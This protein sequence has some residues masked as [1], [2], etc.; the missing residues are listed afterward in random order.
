MSVW[1]LLSV[2]TICCNYQS[3]AV[4]Q[5]INAWLADS[6]LRQHAAIFSITN[7]PFVNWHSAPSPLMI[8]VSLSQLLGLC[9]LW[10]KYS[11]CLHSSKCKAISI[12]FELALRQPNTLGRLCLA[13]PWQESKGRLKHGKSATPWFQMSVQEFTSIPCQTKQNYYIMISTTS[14]VGGFKMHILSN[15]KVFSFG[16]LVG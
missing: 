10:R 3:Y 12:M 15:Y 1:A 6:V 4:M 7:F 13:P 9:F 5:N 14:W 8:Q 11:P 2:C 16:R